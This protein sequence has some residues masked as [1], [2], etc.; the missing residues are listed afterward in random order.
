MPDFIITAGAD[1]ASQ[2]FNEEK[3][4]PAG[5]SL[6]FPRKGPVTPEG[7]SGIRIGDEIRI[8][9]TGKIVSLSDDTGSDWPGAG[10]EIRLELTGCTFGAED[11]GAISLDE[12]LETEEKG[13]RRMR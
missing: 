7:W 5:A 6:S 10:K 11:E 9:L 8:A 13:R 12:A 4:P 3:I 1:A 2:P